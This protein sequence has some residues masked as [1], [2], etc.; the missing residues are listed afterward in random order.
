MIPQ[1]EIEFLVRFICESDAIESITNDPTFVRTQLENDKA[2]GHVGA[3]LHLRE[4]V[5]HKV[6]LSPHLIKQTQSLIVREQAEKGERAIATRH[7]GNWRDCNVSVSGRMC[8]GHQDVSALTLML[9]EKLAHFQSIWSE[10]LAIERVTV[11]ARFHYEYL[12]IHPF[13]DGNGRSAR[14][15]SYYLYRFAGLTPFVFTANDRHETY[16]RCFD[17][18]MDMIEYFH[19]R[20]ILV[21]REKAPHE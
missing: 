14:A 19:D 20:T 2:R 8:A 21:T 3:M 5:K 17:N 18:P 15:L 13:V 9:M 6:L 10:L 16:Y 7:L 12:Q 4:C 11:I 1:K